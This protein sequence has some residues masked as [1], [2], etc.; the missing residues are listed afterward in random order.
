V[1]HAADCLRYLVMGEDHDD[2]SP[3]AAYASNPFA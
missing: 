3:G 2:G 1:D